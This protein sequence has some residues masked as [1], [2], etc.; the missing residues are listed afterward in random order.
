[1]REMKASEVS[2]AFRPNTT[3]LRQKQ[4]QRP[5][6]ALHVK[7]DDKPET[8]ELAQKNYSALYRSLLALF[9]DVHDCTCSC[10]CNVIG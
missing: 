9:W 6:D 7:K 5:A 4:Q 8:I 10:F 1:M 2:G 3:T